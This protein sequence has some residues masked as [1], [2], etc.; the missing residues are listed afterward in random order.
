MS[1]DKRRGVAAAE[2][3]VILPVFLLIV[4]GSIEAVSMIFLKQSV[5]IAAYEGAR[6]ALVPR[7]DANNV[8]GVCQQVLQDR[9][10]QGE[11]INI[12]PGNFATAAYGTIIAVTVSA[13]CDQNSPII[14][15]FYGGDTITATVQMMKET[16]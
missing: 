2:F 5:T 13:P 6:V 9:D 8:I 3:A 1:K 12:T 4:F 14:P 11:T 10:V 16:E 7:S 15:W